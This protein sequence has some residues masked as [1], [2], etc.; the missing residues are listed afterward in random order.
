M[1]ERVPSSEIK[2]ELDS[3]MRKIF[4]IIGFFNME[5]NF[6][7]NQERLLEGAVGGA[8]DAFAEFPEGEAVDKRK[9]LV[10]IHA[11]CLMKNHYHLL[12]SERVTGGIALFTRK[13]NGG[14]A[15]GFNSTHK[16][17]G[18]LFQGVS[19]K[20]RIERHAHFL[21]ILHY[22]HLN[23][24]DYLRDAKQWRERDKGGIHNVREV[25]RY[26]DDYRWS[27]FL[28]Y[29]GKKNFPSILETRLFGA[30]LGEY[31]E[32]IGDYLSEFEGPLPDDKL[33]LE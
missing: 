19:K 3:A 6:P 33:L 21:Y 9:L 17:I 7:E 24:L 18:V 5:K 20:V 22:I 8:R 15:R 12:L 2:L 10:H 29:C 14:Y 27:S 11:F 4:E 13:L 25:L 31:R 1:P 30:A 16:R 32:T 26:L 28:D 23:P